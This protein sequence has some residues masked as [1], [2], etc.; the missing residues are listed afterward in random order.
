MSFDLKFGDNVTI[1]T[2]L[3]FPSTGDRF[4]IKYVPVDNL[5]IH[6]RGN[7]VYIGYGMVHV[8][9]NSGSKVSSDR[10]K[11]SKQ[12]SENS[13]HRFTR[14]LS[15]D[16]MKGIS[17]KFF[18]KLYKENNHKMIVEKIAFEGRDGCVTNLSLS[19]NEHMRLFFH[20]AEW[21]VDNQ[22]NQRLVKGYEISM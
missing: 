11:L 7:V 22:D 14:I 19:Y 10:H 6:Q 20:A 3:K 17:R 9:E 13:W 2:T 18:E 5:F 12:I 15:N 4:V 1:T 21:L 16:L 8:E